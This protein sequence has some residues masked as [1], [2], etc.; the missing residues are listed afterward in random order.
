MCQLGS[1][2]RVVGS[3]YSS[4]PVPQR[5]NQLDASVNLGRFRQ[6]AMFNDRDYDVPLISRDFRETI[7]G[8]F[9]CFPKRYNR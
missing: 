6:S 3:Q 4:A 1:L 7:Q 9:D 5:R 2:I 8:R